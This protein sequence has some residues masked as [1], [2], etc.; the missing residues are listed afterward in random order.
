MILAFSKPEFIDKI[1]NG[2]KTQTI[3]ADKN[4]RWKPGKRIHFRFGF[5]R[6]KGKPTFQFGTGVCSQVEFVSIFPSKNRVCNHATGQIIEG[7]ELLNEF[8]QR[9]GFNTWNDM[10]GFFTKDFFG[11]IIYWDW[12]Q[13][14]W[15]IYECK[16]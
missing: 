4:Q 3:R 9:D 1:K 10:K 16:R 14:N 2:T 15:E 11:R 8:A 7:K 12:K 5:A 6:V 13:C